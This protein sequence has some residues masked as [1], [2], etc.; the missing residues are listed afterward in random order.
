M[1][2]SRK[3]SKITVLFRKSHFYPI[4][5]ANK[6]D[7]KISNFCQKIVFVPEIAIFGG[8]NFNL[9]PFSLKKH[10]KMVIFWGSKSQCL[11]RKF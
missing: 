7:A 6:L 11:F 3:M 8:I 1:K 4:L 5:H 2:K 10:R 9:H